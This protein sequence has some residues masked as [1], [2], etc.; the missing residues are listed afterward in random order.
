MTEEDGSLPV[1]TLLETSGSPEEELVRVKASSADSISDVQENSK[2]IAK[3]S[4]AKTKT[5]FIFHL[6]F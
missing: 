1:S 5:L 3:A 6:L 4:T 2:S